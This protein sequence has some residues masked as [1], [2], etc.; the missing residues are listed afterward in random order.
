MLLA[1]QKPGLTIGPAQAN[2]PLLVKLL[3][4]DLRALGYLRGNVDGAYGPGTEKAVRALQFDLLHNDGQ[5]SGG[6]GLAPVALIDIN[7]DQGNKAVTEVTGVLDQVLAGCIAALIADERIPKLPSSAQ[8]PTENT[9]ALQ[10]IAGSVSTLV[11]TPFIAAIVRQESGG[12]HY[13]VPD[14]RNEDNFIVVGLDHGQAADADRVTS[15]GYGIGQYTLFHHPPRPEEVADFMLDPVRNVSKAET[16]LREKF[17]RFVVSDKHGSDDR[18]AEH[19]LLPLRICRYAPS[20]SRYLRDCRNCAS[21]ASK[22]D[23]GP[24]TP[25]YAGAAITYQVDQYYPSAIYRGVP[26]RADFLC[27]WPY[28]VRRYNGGGLDSYHYQTRVLLN[29]LNLPG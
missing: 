7:R 13:R 24:G 19:P 18:K 23:I 9:K 10:T 2:D 26:H 1:Y 15:R 25:V 6:D 20:D 28:A 5:S 16:E 21:A 11:P 17:D 27:D 4:R 12:Q 22:T 3:Q 8:A 14:G 29:L